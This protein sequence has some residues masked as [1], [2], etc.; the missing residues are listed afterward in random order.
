MVRVGDC[1]PTEQAGKK[2]KETFDRRQASNKNAC[3]KR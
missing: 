2:R 1:P 3:G